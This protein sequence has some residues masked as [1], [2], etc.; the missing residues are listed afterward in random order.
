MEGIVVIEES[1]D[2]LPLYE[3]IPM[4]FLASKKVSLDGLLESQG[5]NMRE[6][7]VEPFRKDYD[8]CEEDRP[9]SLPKRFDV[10]NW[11]LIGAFCDGRRIGGAILA[12]STPGLNMLEGR[13]DL[14]LIMDIRVHPDSRGQHI[15]EAVMKGALEWAAR[16]CCTELKVET[17]DINGPAC[18]F[19]YSQG[20]RLAEV[21]ERVYEGLDETQLI[22]RKPI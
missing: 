22:W 1:T 3:Q 21:N 19:Y 17:Q 15:G 8:D 2:V 16:N 4:A 9:T 13:D 5:A 7:E 11:A 12:R 20:F 6:I 18:R 10:S 14:A